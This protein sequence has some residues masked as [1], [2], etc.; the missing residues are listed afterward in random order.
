MEGVTNI[1]RS[2]NCMKR[3]L[4]CLSAPRVPHA[5]GDNPGPHTLIKKSPVP[6]G[7]S[8]P[9]STWTY[10][11]RAAVIPMTPDWMIRA[12]A[13]ITPAIIRATAT[14]P[15]LSSSHSFTPLVRWSRTFNAI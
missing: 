14:F 4:E 6:A 7:S 3:Y 11:I 8:P 10:Q 5:R 12:V 15:F 1:P 13:M 2:L 9:G